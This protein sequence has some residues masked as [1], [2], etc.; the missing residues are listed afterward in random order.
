MDINRQRQIVHDNFISDTGETRNNGSSTFT[1]GHYVKTEYHT[2]KYPHIH[3]H[4]VGTQHF[5]GNVGF[6]SQNTVGAI[7]AEIANAPIRDKKQANGI[8][9]MN[10]V[11]R[12]VR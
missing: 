10:G 7:N 8:L 9:K 3:W 5:Q 6:I 11:V 2:D 1:T 4:E 12:K